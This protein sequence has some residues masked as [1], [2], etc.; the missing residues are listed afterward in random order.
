[1]T[2]ATGCSWPILLKNSFSGAV[3]KILA[4]IGSEACLVVKRIYARVL[5]AL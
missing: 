4:V 5:F 3:E 2:A 1:M